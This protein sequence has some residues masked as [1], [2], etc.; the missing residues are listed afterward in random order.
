MNGGW[1]KLALGERNEIE[2][3][4]ITII[5]NYF[6]QIYK[7]PNDFILMVDKKYW[8]RHVIHVITKKLPINYTCN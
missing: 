4:S 8:G 5:V 3:N 1:V 7:L 2:D 6:G